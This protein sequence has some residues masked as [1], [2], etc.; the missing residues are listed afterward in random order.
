MSFLPITIFVPHICSKPF[1]SASTVTFSENAHCAE[2]LFWTSEWVRFQTY[3]WESLGTWSLQSSPRKADIQYGIVA[4]GKDG[5]GQLLPSWWWISE[6]RRRLEDRELLGCRQL[7]EA[8]E[9]E[10]EL[11]MKNALGFDRGGRKA[12][13]D[14]AFHEMGKHKKV[15]TSM[16]VEAARENPRSPGNIQGTFPW[17]DC[18]QA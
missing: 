8:D 17:K 9:L 13:S 4:T 3:L 10:V 6:C 18:G 16:L 15:G 2:G 5:S 11:A 12:V 14:E 1:F 7:K